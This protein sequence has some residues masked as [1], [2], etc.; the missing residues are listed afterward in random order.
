[1]NRQNMENVLGMG[2]LSKTLY[3]QQEDKNVS[4]R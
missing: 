1:M 4:E 3:W 2:A